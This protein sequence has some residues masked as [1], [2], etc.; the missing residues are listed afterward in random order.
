M[1]KREGIPGG[2]RFVSGAASTSEVDAKR[3]ATLAARAALTG[4]TLHRI[5][6]D[7]G[8]PCFVLT[9]WHLT[10]PLGTL[11][12]VEVWLENLSGMTRRRRPK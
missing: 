3:F 6:A 7:D 5:D 1:R 11:A 2:A 12:D 10:R 9:K 8:S 4:A